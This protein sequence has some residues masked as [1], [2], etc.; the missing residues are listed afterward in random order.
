MAKTVIPNNNS[1]DS[2]RSNNGKE[3]DYC[4]DR[5]IAPCEASVPRY[6]YLNKYAM[7][8]RSGFKGFWEAPFVIL[9]KGKKV[10]NIEY[11]VFVIPEIDHLLR[12]GGKLHDD[13]DL[14][15]I[16]RLVQYGHYKLKPVGSI[17]IYNQILN[18]INFSSKDY[19]ANAITAMKKLGK[20]YGMD[21][22]TMEEHS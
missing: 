6:R 1:Y 16:I 15:R 13:M 17:Q 11:N 9:Q 8:H 22:Q 21:L 5:Y 18:P 12:H 3:F 4:D 2:C 19:E 10:D 7:N 14:S 20:Q